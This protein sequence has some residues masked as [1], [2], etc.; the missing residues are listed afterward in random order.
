MSPPI[1]FKNPFVASAA[2]YAT[3]IKVPN[4]STNPTPT[5]DKKFTLASNAGAIFERSGTNFNSLTA[6]NPSNIF[7]IKFLNHPMIPPLDDSAAA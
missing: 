6:K 2:E 5:E 7:P 1:D 4:P 3:F